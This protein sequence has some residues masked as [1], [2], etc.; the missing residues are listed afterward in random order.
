MKKYLYFLKEEYFKIGILIILALFLFVAHQYANYKRYDP[1]LQDDYI[2]DTHTGL[3][4]RT[5]NMIVP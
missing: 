3:V 5:N 4:H 2:L 1:I